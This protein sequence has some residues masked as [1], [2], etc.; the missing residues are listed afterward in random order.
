MHE[1]FEGVAENAVGECSLPLKACSLTGISCS[2]QVLK[3]FEYVAV[4]AV[5]AK[6]PQSQYELS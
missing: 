5:G 2:Q 3:L 1:I 6:I 4:D